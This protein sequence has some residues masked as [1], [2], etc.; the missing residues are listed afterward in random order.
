VIEIVG[1][2]F[3]AVDLGP[4][5]IVGAAAFN[6]FI[7]I[8]ICMYVCMSA[9]MYARCYVRSFADSHIADRQNVN[10]EISDSNW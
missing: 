2:H 6:F 10:I 7:I 5:T 8:A 1:S 9:C 3:K 4:G